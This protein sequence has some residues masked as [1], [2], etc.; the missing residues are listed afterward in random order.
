MRFDLS[1][2]SEVNIKIVDLS[3]RVI[4]NQRVGTMSSGTHIVPI[5]T[6]DLASGSYFAVLSANRKMVGSKLF[7]RK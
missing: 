1:L 6:T 7:I 4:M 3:G 2:N 5:N